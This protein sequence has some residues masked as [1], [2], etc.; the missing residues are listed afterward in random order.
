MNKD[1]RYILLFGGIISL[2]FGILL[3]TRPDASL[4]LIMLLVGLGWF[5]QGIVT[6]LGI[7]IDRSSWGW[8]LFGGAIGIA[9]GLLVLQNPLLSTEVV[10]AVLALL[11]GIFGVLIGISSLIAVFQGGGW[12]AGIFGAISLVIGLLFVFNAYIA[13]EVMIWLFAVLLLVQGGIGVFMSLFS[14]SADEP[15]ASYSSQT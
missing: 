15:S 8:K 13:S 14:K 1:D 4:A 5:I 7:F 11:M 10:P 3:L 6:L 12:S 2:I 9:A